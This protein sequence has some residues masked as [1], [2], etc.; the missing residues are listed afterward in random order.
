METDPQEGRIA[1]F[2]E[3]PIPADW[4]RYDLNMRQTFWGGGLKDGGSVQ[5]VQRK[6][7][8][9][10]EIMKELFNYSDMVTDRRRAREINATLQKLGWKPLGY[11]DN[12]GPHGRQRG[13]AR[14]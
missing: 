8:C 6:K 13:Y 10:A 9:A 12:Y 3:R 11:P 14:P 1:E 5:L 4:Q 2:L 7:V